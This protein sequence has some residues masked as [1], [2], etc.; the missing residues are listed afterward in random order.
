MTFEVFLEAYDEAEEAR[1][2]YFDED[3]DLAVDFV[4][5]LRATLARIQSTPE[6]FPKERH[7]TRKAFLHRFPFKVIYR[8]AS[9]QLTIIAVA[10]MSRKPGYWRER[11]DRI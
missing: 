7:R 4:A 3:P 5:E 11:L 2:R 10:H 8:A 6:F 9:D 1:L